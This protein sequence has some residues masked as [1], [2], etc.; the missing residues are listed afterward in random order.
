MTSR[1]KIDNSVKYITKSEQTQSIS[2]ERKKIVSNP[3]KQNKKISQSH[4]T[5]IEG[6]TGTGF[7]ILE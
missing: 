3:R 6:F 4:E 1:K 5:F 2:K 7:R